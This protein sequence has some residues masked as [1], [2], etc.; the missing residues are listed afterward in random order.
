[1]K[2]ASSVDYNGILSKLKI[3][4]FI[5]VPWATI[6][7]TQYFYKHTLLNHYPNQCWFIVNWTLWNKAM[8][9]SNKNKTI[10]CQK[11]N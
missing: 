10:L 3:N 1:M 8:W 7:Y 6:F 2:F 11:I 4:D 9:N 5:I